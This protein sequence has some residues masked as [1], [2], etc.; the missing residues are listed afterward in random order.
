LFA[1]R[2]EEIAIIA[3]EDFIKQAT[4]AAKLNARLVDDISAL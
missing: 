2:F 3:T 1:G 4:T